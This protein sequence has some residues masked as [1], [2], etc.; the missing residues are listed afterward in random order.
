M[1]KVRLRAILI[2]LGL[3]VLSAG[4]YWAVLT[5]VVSLGL[6][7]P[8]IF[9]IIAGVTALGAVKIG[10]WAPALTAG[11]GA[12]GFALAGVS[13]GGILSLGGSAVFIGA[14]LATLGVLGYVVSM[15][16]HIGTRVYSVTPA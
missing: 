16:Y 8:L 12:L 10:A 1:E 7:A 5:D 9:T 14:V 13:V 2:P 6:Y 3:F 4:A 15:V 11:I